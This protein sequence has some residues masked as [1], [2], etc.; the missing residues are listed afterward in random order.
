MTPKLVTFDC[1]QTLVRVPENW[2]LGQ[3]AV[4][5]AHHVGLNPPDGAASSYQKM[6]FDRIGEFLE[7]NRSRDMGRADQFWRALGAEWI[8]AMD[9]PTSSLE[10]LRLAGEELGFGDKSILFSLFE[11]VVPCLDLLDSMGIQAGVVSNWDYSLHRVLR[12]FGIDE[13]FVVVKASLE[14]GVEKPDPRLFEI[15]LK[16]AGFSP[17]DTFHVGDSVED[18]LAGAKAASIR[19]ALIDRAMVDPKPPYIRSLLELPEA[20]AWSG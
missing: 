19:V 18:D 13:R 5:C 8:A 15:A 14:E 12:M 7:I 2:T 4:D 6:Y 11:D 3:F 9:L 17:E 16:D 20:F 10:Q 1:A